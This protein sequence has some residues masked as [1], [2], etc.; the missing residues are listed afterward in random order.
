MPEKTG[1]EDKIVKK[2]RKDGSIDQ[3]KL[4]ENMKDD[5]EKILLSLKYLMIKDIISYT[6]DWELKIRGDANFE[7]W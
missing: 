6:V 3:E 5:R 1:I 2:I 7:S 4:I